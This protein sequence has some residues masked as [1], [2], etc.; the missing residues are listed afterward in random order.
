VKKLYSE[1]VDKGVINA[2]FIAANTNLIAIA[3]QIPSRS[4]KIEKDATL[5]MKRS[6]ISAPK[7]SNVAAIS[8]QTKP[9]AP[10]DPMEVLLLATLPVTDGDF[11]AL[12]SDRAKAVR[13][14]ILQTG[15]VEAARL[16]LAEN[17]TG[18]VR[19]DGSR[20][21]LQLR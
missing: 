10:T 13:A 12:A 17:Q 16:F 2:A 9:A 11:E 3:A 6:L 1:A 18:G 21:Y 19:S 20:V 4:G 15:K 5:L 14:Y 8:N 7:S